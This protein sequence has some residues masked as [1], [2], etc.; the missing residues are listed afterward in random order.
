MSILRRIPG[1]RFSEVEPLWAG[2]LA[3][4]IGGGP[5]LTPEHVALVHAQRVRGIYCI[6]VNDAYL[7]APWADVCYFADSHWWKWQTVGTPKPQL[8]LS[9]EQVRERFSAFA[10]EKCTI[11]NSGANVTDERVHMLRNRDHPNLGHGL[12]LDP[13][14]LVTGR[15]SGF[16]AINLAVLAGA[17]TI[18]LL[19]YDGRPSADG[20]AH[21]FGEH[22]RPTPAAAYEYYRKAYSAAERE[23]IA[24]GVKVLNCSPGSAIDSF[25]KLPLECALEA[26]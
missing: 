4:L 18:I 13:R 17:R 19:G 20:K 21:F 14:V 16:Q 6:A 24:A 8:G 10:G 9:G 7:L 25:E 22:P 3:V 11:E 5:S 12:S 23:I 15:H 1:E 2:G 26:H